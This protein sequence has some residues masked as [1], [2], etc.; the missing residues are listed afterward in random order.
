MYRAFEACEG[1][2][3]T[4]TSPSLFYIRRLTFLFSG[5][6]KVEIQRL[7]NRNVSCDPKCEGDV[8]EN[9]KGSRGS[10][11][12]YI[13]IWEGWCE[14]VRVKSPIPVFLTFASS[15]TETGLSEKSNRNNTPRV[16]KISFGVIVNTFVET[17]EMVKR[18]NAMIHYQKQLPA[19]SLDSKT[20][21]C[22]C[23]SSYLQRIAILSLP[24]LSKHSV[25][26]LRA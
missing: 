25:I 24:S 7:E 5:D 20:S 9:E 23:F 8:R 16:T 18:T 2:W 21:C 4:L 3:F 6:A 12:L 11:P 26:A 19:F 1:K 13:G 22:K 15:A 10:T 17:Q 14:Y